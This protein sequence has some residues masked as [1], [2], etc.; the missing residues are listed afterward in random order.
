MRIAI[1]ILLL[2][3]NIFVMYSF[4]SSLK[5]DIYFYESIH[6]YVLFAQKEAIKLR[7]KP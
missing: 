2:T 6:D 3:I 5:R 4:Y 7:V 1:Q